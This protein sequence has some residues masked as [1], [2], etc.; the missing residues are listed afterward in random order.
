[1]VEDDDFAALLAEYEGKENKKKRKE[2]RVGEEV[3][4]RIVS[5]GRDAAF[6]DF[7]GKS[8]G[9]LDLVELRDHEGKVA[10]Q[11]GDEIEA[12]VVEPEGPKGGVVLRRV[13]G[14]AGGGRAVGADARAE[15][16]DAHAH[17][18]PVEGLVTGVNKGG[19]EVQVAGVRAFCPI[20]QLELRHVDDA[21][22]YVGQRLMFRVT[23]YD[24]GS[25]RADVILSRRMILEEEQA[26]Q[27]Q[28]TRGKLS[29][30][31]VV[32]GKVTAIK[33]YG[34]FVDIGGVEGMLHVSELGFS[35][36]KH[37]SDVLKVG[38]ELEV[39]VK[40]LEGDRISLSLKS[41]ERDPWSALSLG[42]GSRAAGPVTRLE[43]F[44][45]FVEVAPGVE[46]LVHVS[47]LG[48]GRPLK[49]ARDAAKLGQRLEVVVLSVDAGNRRLSLGLAEEGGGDEGGEAPPMAPAAPK[50][51]G[52][53]ADLMNKNKK[54]K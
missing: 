14:R 54:K 50:K 12:R 41:L 51:L 40:K 34:A 29:Q 1:M 8:D 16:A 52:T 30:G 3:K 27:A 48:R 20:S 38:Q 18:L 24:E 26:A 33:D 36:V 9:V 49:H 23:R 15:L 35:R 46:G 39:Q 17:G 43:A 25:G 31:A 6:V 45:A 19:V 22:V 5:I 32:H 21:S 7:G 2:P 42:E 44:G 10:V 13:I 11:V 47:E 53:F 4:G 28:V 37:P